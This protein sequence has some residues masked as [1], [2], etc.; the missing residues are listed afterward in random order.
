[1]LLPL[2][3]DMEEVRRH[4]QTRGMAQDR[5]L[6]RTD[7]ELDPL[8]QVLVNMPPSKEHHDMEPPHRLLVHPGIAMEAHLLHTAQNR[9]QH[10]RHL[11][12]KVVAVRASPKDME[13][14]RIGSL[15]PKSKKRKMFSGP[16]RKSGLSSSLT[17][18]LHV[19]H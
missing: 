4:L 5:L 18:L 6:D 10:H 14:I 15:Q 12:G 3:R 11:L 17:F 1:M 13:L 8:R 16:S 7:S 2:L 19:M 9:M